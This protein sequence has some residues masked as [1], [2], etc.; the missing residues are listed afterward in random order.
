MSGVSIVKQVVKTHKKLSLFQRAIYQNIVKIP[1][2]NFKSLCTNRKHS[3][4]FSSTM[5]IDTAPEGK[6]D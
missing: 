1:E 2:S 6:E 4:M 5:K 3:T